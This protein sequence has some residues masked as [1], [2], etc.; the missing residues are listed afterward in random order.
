MKPWYMSKTIWIGV[1]EIVGGMVWLG[2]CLFM[3]WSDYTQGT[4]LLVLGLKDIGLR[5]FTNTA[6]K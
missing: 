6:V 4:G 1:G 5:A 2:V 3:G